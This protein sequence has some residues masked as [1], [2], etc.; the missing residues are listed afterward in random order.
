MCLLVCHSSF[1]T[2]SFMALA[3]LQKWKDLLTS[4]TG[5]WIKTM[6]FGIRILDLHQSCNIF[7]EVAVVLKFMLSPFEFTW[8]CNWFDHM[9][10]RDDYMI[11]NYKCQTASALISGTHWS[12]E[13]TWN[14]D[15]GEAIWRYSG[16]KF[17]QNEAFQLSQPRHQA[18]VKSSLVLWTSPADR[19][20]PRSNLHETWNRRITSLNPVPMLDC[21]V[22]RCHR[23]LLF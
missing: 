4:Q 18:W 17:Q 7:C 12:L 5:Q 20:I 9:I 21:Q 19:W 1:S 15:S 2:F 3:A 23:C 22:T 6:E 13:L 11:F 8:A 10:T 16:Q 14:H